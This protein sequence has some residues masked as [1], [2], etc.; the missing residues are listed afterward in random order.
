MP[1]MEPSSFSAAMTLPVATSA[2]VVVIRT[3][4]PARW[5]VPDSTQRQPSRRPMSCGST[6]ASALAHWRTV[7]STRSRGTTISPGRRARS[8][9]TLSAMPLPTQSFSV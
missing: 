8:I 3:A 9:V 5:N 6:L 7:R 2:R 1:S 4:D